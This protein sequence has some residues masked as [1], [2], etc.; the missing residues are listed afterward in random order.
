MRNE[1]AIRFG[2][3]CNNI[4]LERMGVGG[5]PTNYSNKF[6]LNTEA[7]NIPSLLKDGHGSERRCAQHRG[8]LLVPARPSQATLTS[9]SHSQ[10]I[11]AQQ[12]AVLPVE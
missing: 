7:F 10:V 9:R 4:M 12:L 11:C 6:D 1:Q 5:S 2:E 3:L 8:E